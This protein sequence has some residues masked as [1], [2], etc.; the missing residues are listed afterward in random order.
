[1]E[2]INF[3]DNIAWFNIKLLTTFNLQD[4]TKFMK[5]KTYASA[6]KNICPK[7]RIPTSHCV[8]I[9]RILGSYECELNEDPREEISNLCNWGLSVPLGIVRSKAH[10]KKNTK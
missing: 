5:D 2:E 7:K 6:V 9:G 3:Y 1:M 10:L 8:H 4:N